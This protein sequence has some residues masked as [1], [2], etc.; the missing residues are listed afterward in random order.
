VASTLR[1]AEAGVGYI[2]LSRG[3]LQ[4]RSSGHGTHEE[5]LSVSGGH[6][7]GTVCGIL[8]CIPAPLPMCTFS[9][10]PHTRPLPHPSSPIRYDTGDSGY[11]GADGYV[12]V[13]ARTDDVLNVA[14]HRLASGALEEVRRLR[15]PKHRAANGN[16]AVKRAL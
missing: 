9:F 1:I 15:A 2:S 11:V 13:M 10:C 6:R 14:G 3:V 16:G 5:R 7:L 4:S 12:H 8:A